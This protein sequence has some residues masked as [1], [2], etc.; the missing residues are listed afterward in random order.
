VSRHA[1]RDGNLCIEA[2][3]PLAH[4][5]MICAVSQCTAVSRLRPGVRKTNDALLSSSREKKDCHRS[6]FR[7]LFHD[8][9]CQSYLAIDGIIHGHALSSR[10]S[11]KLDNAVA[12]YLV[13]TVILIV[14]KNGVCRRM[15]TSLTTCVIRSRT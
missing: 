10:E 4:T 3:E 6:S 14:S 1:R 12:H 9:G 11:N 13:L 2:D 15:L 5:D 7:C 8:N